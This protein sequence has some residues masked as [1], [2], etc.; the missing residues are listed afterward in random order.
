MLKTGRILQLGSEGAQ[1]DC[2]QN[3]GFLQ[4]TGE[5]NQGG[6]GWSS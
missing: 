6:L 4:E 5:P 3:P 1:Q 2:P